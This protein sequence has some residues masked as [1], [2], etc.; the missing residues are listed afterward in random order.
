MGHEHRLSEKIVEDHADEQEDDDFTDN[1]RVRVHP[2]P[3]PREDGFGPLAEAEEDERREGQKEHGEGDKPERVG[4]RQTVRSEVGSNGD[5]GEDVGREEPKQEEAESERESWVR[6]RQR[7]HPFR[8]F[9]FLARQVGVYHSDEQNDQDDDRERGVRTAL[10]VRADAEEVRK[11]DEEGDGERRAEDERSG[12]PSPILA[13]GEE[14]G[15]EKLR[16]RN[17]D[18]RQRKDS[19]ETH[20]PRTPEY[21]IATRRCRSQPNPRS[22]WNFGPVMSLLPKHDETQITESCRSGYIGYLTS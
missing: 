11:R 10:A 6:G 5:R 7:P 13:C 3:N 1:P 18:E 16:P 9:R 4:P 2:L 12:I 15:T 14:D 17:H 22:T 20:R 21:R 8:R 19:E